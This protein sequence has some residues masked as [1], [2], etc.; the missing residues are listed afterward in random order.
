MEQYAHY[1]RTASDSSE[2]Q[3]QKLQSTHEV[4]MNEVR[5]L[6]QSHRNF[7]AQQEKAGVAQ[8]E[9]AMRHNTELLKQSMA[10][11]EEQIKQI[12]QAHRKQ[13]DDLNQ[14]FQTYVDLS[15]ATSQLT[16]EIRSVDFPQRLNHMASAVEDFTQ[17][18]KQTYGQM[19]AIQN[20]VHQ[21]TV[22]DWSTM[23]RIPEFVKNQQ[24]QLQ[25]IRIAAIAAA[26]LA[27]A[28]TILGVLF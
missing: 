23:A 9:T 4:E 2:V 14:V 13:I 8:L 10:T 1:L 12:T 15:Q 20:D 17:T 3:M 24:N 26:A 11:T 28:A 25:Q 19:Q 6:V 7:L 22:V 21:V 5:K 27:L 18:V 16:R